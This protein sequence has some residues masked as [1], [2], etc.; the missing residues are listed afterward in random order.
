MNAEVAAADVAAMTAEAEGA[1]AQKIQYCRLY[2]RTAK[3]EVWHSLLAHLCTVWGQF[4]RVPDWADGC[5]EEVLDGQCA[6]CLAASMMWNVVFY[7]S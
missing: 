1:T 2:R 5:G 3:Y 6:W 4:E 7:R